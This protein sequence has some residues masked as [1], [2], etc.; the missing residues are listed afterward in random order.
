MKETPI[1]YDIVTKVIKESN[2]KSFSTAT[3]RMI[4]KLVDDVE[5]ATGERYIRM[6]MGV[7]GLSPS[8][9]G[10]EAEREAHRQGLAAIYPDIQGIPEFKKEASRFV[11]LFLNIDVD[12]EGCIPTVGSTMGSFATFLTVNQLWEGRDTT[13]FIDPGFPLHKQQHMVLGINSESFDIYEYRGDKLHDK[14]ESY[15]SK[16]NISCI[17]YCSPNN[18]AWICF[19]E[20]EL[21]IIGELADKYNVIVVED[22]AYFAMDFRKKYGV[23][24][25]PPFQPS[26]SHY[27]DNYILLISSSKVFSYAGQRIGMMVMSDK[28]FNI[29][30]PYLLKRFIF[31][32]LGPCMTFGTL[33]AL[34]AGTAHTPQR[35]LTAMLK[36]MNDGTYKPLEE[37]KEYAARAAIM[38]KLFT[39]N[40]FRIVYD[41]DEND[42]IADGFYFTLAYPGMTSE[43]LLSELMYYGISAI[44]LTVC[45]SQRAEGLRACVSLVQRDQFP[46]LKSRLEAFNQNHK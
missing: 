24:G 33:Y 3:I 6:E 41:M 27:S 21:S 2:I 7:P 42:P 11:K 13:L 28:V 36:A 38:K 19:S 12:P 8:S 9:I 34:S 44:S 39:D 4:K 25:Q 29:R 32:Q 35:A 46:A 31:D 45:R 43:E 5:R 40:G 30:S 10:I 26:V 20:K 18:P 15:L 16:G 14:L 17:I 1:N 22:L 37:V 23:P